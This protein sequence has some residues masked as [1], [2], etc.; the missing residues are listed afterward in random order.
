M[1]FTLIKGT[2]R[3]VNKTKLGNATGFEPDGDSMQFHPYNA[4]LL[5]Q[6]DQLMTPY[7]LT[8]IG[9]VQL[10][11]E[12]IDALELHFTAGQGGTTHQPRPL[13]DEAR[14]TLVDEANL[15]PVTY[16]PPRN[17][18]VQP[19]APHDAAG[20]YIMSRSLDVHGRPVVFAFAGSTSE[21]DGTS[22]R[23]TPAGLRRSLNHKLITA[24]QAYPLFYDTLFFDLRD[25]LAA[26]A[27][28]AR[29]AKRGLWKQDLTLK[30]T[31][32]ASIAQLEAKAVV[33]PKL[34]RRMAEYLGEG[35]TGV[36]GFKQW[37][38]DKK[39]RVFDLD[40]TN[41]THFDTYIDVANGKVSLNK[42]PRRLVFVSAKGR[43]PW[44]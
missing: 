5:D 40:T 30:G 14:D 10:R 34:F 18:R 37:I 39:E 23:L 35:N 41:N 13:A 4:K 11:F 20:G 42:D 15:D 27:A 25:E 9:S 22:V 2:F 43:V 21:R 36:T 3:L 24:G 31:S 32:G 12:G 28:T 19:P 8:A 17:I 33:F 26:A 16:A 6:L 7:R 29:T 44:L 38:A 1:P